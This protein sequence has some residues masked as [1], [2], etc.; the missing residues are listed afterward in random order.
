LGRYGGGR[1]TRALRTLRSWVDHRLS[2]DEGARPLET[3]LRRFIENTPDGIFT[4]RIGGRVVY[5]NRAFAEF[6]GYSADEAVELTLDDILH[7]EDREIVSQRVRSIVGTGQPSVPRTIRF[8]G[9][10]RTV[11]YAETRGMATAFEGEP[12]VMVIA[13]DLTERIEA[14]KARR[15]SEA[16]FAAVF[17]ANPLPTALSRMSDQC[18]I[19]VNDRFLELFELERRQVI[20]HSGSDFNLWMNP[21][22]RDKIYSE[23]ANGLPIRD[24]E[25]RWRST[26]GAVRDF[27]LSVEPL[28][29]GDVECAIW[30]A[31]EVTEHRQI[32]EHLRQAQKM[33]AIGRLAGGV[34]HDFNNILT[35]ILGFASGAL[36]EVEGNSV[37]RRRITQIEE[38]AKRAARLTHQLL[39]FARKQVRQPVVLDLSEVVERMST[40]LQ[41]II[42]EDIELVV[43]LESRPCRV[44]LD[45]G[46]M[47]QILLNLTVNARDAMAKGG[48]LAISTRLLDEEPDAK[49]RLT[50][51]D[52]GIGM[53]DELMGHIFEPF[54]T[55]KE[56]GKGTGLGLS[57]VYSVVEQSG[58]TIHVSSVVGKGTVFEITFPSSQD[59]QISIEVEEEW[60]SERQHGD[61]TVLLVEDDHEVR[62][63][64]SSVL[65]SSG[66]RVI[67][68]TDG[69]VAIRV[70]E[71]LAVRID[72]LLSDVVM[73]GMS[74]IE[75]ARRVASLRPSIRVLHMSGYPGDTLARYGRPF[76]TAA[77]IEKP[78]SPH[79][80][81]RKIRLVLDAQ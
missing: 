1:L 3:D 81:A 31:Y 15:R 23:I 76:S 42:G 2:E 35:A 11:R 36:E 16:Q 4:H 29:V 27:L 43:E 45:L 77:W 32:E 57:M 34:A 20:G 68:A 64:V 10:D 9:K 13:R 48:R 65:A 22:V 26:S 12:G 52:T 49:V 25:M 55:T 67:E 60:A 21:E 78:F 7:H 66:Y 56:V 46:E 51:R 62:E 14:E 70:A 38:A 19:D 5:V 79:S 71:D 54:F 80:L 53:D 28:T 69:N 8:L 6:L 33:E 59:Q 41:R 18:F 17:H 40:M 58:G 50:V 39:L 47:E 61:E 37:A 30:L 72:L 63:L 44:V 24:R 75:L 73:P 74:G